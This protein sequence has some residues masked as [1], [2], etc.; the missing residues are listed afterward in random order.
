MQNVRPFLREMPTDL[1]TKTT[2]TFEIVLK[3]SKMYL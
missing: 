1:R 2:P 3:L